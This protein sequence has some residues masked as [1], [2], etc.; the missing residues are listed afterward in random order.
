MVMDLD[1][2][3]KARKDKGLSLQEALK[4]TRQLA[5]EKFEQITGM[6]ETNPNALWHHRNSAFGTDCPK[7]GKPYRTPQARYCAECGYNMNSLNAPGL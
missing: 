7:C 6:K 2:I 5:F 1:A 3:R 4:A